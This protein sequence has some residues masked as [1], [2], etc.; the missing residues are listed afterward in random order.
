MKYWLCIGVLLLASSPALAQE[1]DAGGGLFGEGD[2]EF[3]TS[4]PRGERRPAGPG[5]VDRINEIL[6]KGGY[7]LSEDQKKTLQQ[8]LD[9]QMDDIRAALAPSPETGQE[10]AGSGR[11]DAGAPGLQRRAPNPA[12][13]RQEEIYLA[14]VL[15]ILTP[16]Q[17]GVWKK[18]QADQIRARGGYPA[19]K[20]ALAE[21]GS[22]PTPEQDT[23]LQEQFRTYSE[24]VR[25]LRDAAPGGQPDAAKLK[26]LETQHL[27]AL[28][29]LLDATQ[30]KALLEWR[31]S[32]PSAAPR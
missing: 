21:A 31:R 7:P 14:K 6:G 8:L 12:L 15:P 29:K 16:E 9:E 3:S 26:E 24:Q 20:L 2:V 17:Q 28:V 27:T 10:A 32:A 23:Q 4:G 11:R 1:G 30:R 22:A 25:A 19:L 13:L 18:Y 5:P